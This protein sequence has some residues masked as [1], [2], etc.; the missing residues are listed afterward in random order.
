MKYRFTNFLLRLFVLQWLRFYG[1]PFVV[2]LL[3][4][5]VLCLLDGITI[6]ALCLWLIEITIFPLYI[7]ALKA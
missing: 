4:K 6:F 3:L 1:I 2:D 7:V 5:N